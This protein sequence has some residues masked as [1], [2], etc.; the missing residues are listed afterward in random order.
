MLARPLGYLLLACGLCAAAHAHADAKRC[1]ELNNDGLQKRDEHHLLSA[2]DV[3]RACVADKD[4]PGM[5]RA[6]CNDALADIKTAIPTLLVAVVDEEG[7]DLAGA[8][9]AVDGKP[10]LLDGS[11]IEVDPGPHELTAKSAELSSE[12]QVMA[13][14]S[15]LNRRVAIALRAPRLAAPAPEVAMSPPAVVPRRSNLPGYLLG[16]VAASSAIAFGYFALSG[17]LH[18]AELERCRPYCDPN[19][20]Q[21]ART[22]YWGAD[23]SLGVSLVALAGA[24]V[25]LLSSPKGKKTD[26]ASTLSFG[27]IASPRTAGLS[28]RWAE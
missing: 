16:S 10:V 21:R 4:C 26:S 3:Y 22:E 27:M 13:I 8:T 2:R 5:V 20:V 14:E 1:V 28:V 17:H 18:L 9:L 6:E 19:D 24:G 7:H 11:S 23:I 12:L 15:D 25:W